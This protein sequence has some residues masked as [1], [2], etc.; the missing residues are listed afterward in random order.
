MN[1]DLSAPKQSMHPK[2]NSINFQEKTSSHRKAQSKVR[3]NTDDHDN[4][5][6][7]Q[8]R[9]KSKGRKTFVQNNLA[10]E[11]AASQRK[12]GGRMSVRGQIKK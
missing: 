11:T 9:K 10:K 7:S 3:M 2:L 8:Q 4:R 1:R 6:G 5:S 12:L